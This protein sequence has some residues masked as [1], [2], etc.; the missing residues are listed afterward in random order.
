MKDLWGYRLALHCNN[1]GQRPN[2]RA[3]NKGALIFD[4]SYLQCYEFKA[5]SLDHLKSILFSITTGADDNHL[6]DA[7][8]KGQRELTLPIYQRYPDV[9]VANALVNI[10]PCSN[11]AWLWIH[12][13]ASLQFEGLSSELSI[14]K[15]EGLS[16]I[17]LIGRNAMD[18]VC[19]LISA[20]SDKKVCIHPGFIHTDSL[21]TILLEIIKLFFG[22]ACTN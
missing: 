11:T 8:W 10:I 5:E 13:A 15:V 14:S 19:K 21:I 3:I 16:R 18:H 1:K 2:Y 4:I 7:F 9:F 22:G 17:S 6:N 12:P 20:S